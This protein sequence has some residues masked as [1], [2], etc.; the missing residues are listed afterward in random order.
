M[1]NPNDFL[2]IY[3]I[4][5]YSGAKSIYKHPVNFSQSVFII[6]ESHNLTLY[7]ID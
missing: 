3:Y 2:D 4:N 6:D 7:N 1:N 5:S